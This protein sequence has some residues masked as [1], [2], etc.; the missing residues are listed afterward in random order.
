MYD[1]FQLFGH[2][3]YRLIVTIANFSFFCVFC[4]SYSFSYSFILHN[5]TNLSFV[6][7]GICPGMIDKIDFAK[8]GQPIFS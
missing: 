6:S 5:A 2:F 8:K 3:P 1:D 4:D 7:A